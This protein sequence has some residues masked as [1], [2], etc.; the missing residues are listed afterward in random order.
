MRGVEAMLTR[1]EV[2]CGLDIAPSERLA[3]AVAFAEPLD[4]EAIQDIM[5][6]GLADAE[7]F[8]Q[9]TDA[10]DE[11]LEACWRYAG[12]RWGFAFRGG[13]PVLVEPGAE[14]RSHV[15]VMEERLALQLFLQED[16]HGGRHTN[17]E[18]AAVRADPDWANAF[19]D[20]TEAD[21]RLEEFRQGPKAGLARQR[22]DRILEIIACYDLD[23]SWRWMDE[24]S[25]GDESLTG[26]FAVVFEGGAARGRIDHEVAYCDHLG[27]VIERAIHATVLPAKLF[28]AF[29]LDSDDFSRPIT[30]VCE[31]RA[32]GPDGASEVAEW[33]LPC[34]VA[35]SPEA[36]GPAGP[37]R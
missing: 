24:L 22:L 14:P 9:G 2:T 36:P 13:R 7:D 10:C 8:V 29:D 11:G 18:V 16:L 30:V 5:D 20:A 34:V 3:R 12:R 21:E 33:T 1:R 6:A 17:E 31:V 15:H 37:R 23:P 35:G 27:G 32:Q 4:V 28:G 19:R 25:A 26:R